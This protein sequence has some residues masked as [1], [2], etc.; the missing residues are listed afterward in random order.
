MS[1]YQGTF[2]VI[3]NTGAT[4]TNVLATHNT[5][6][7]GNETIVVASLANGASSQPQAFTT[8]TSN[9]DRW[10]VAFINSNNGLDTGY[11]TCG[12]ES[13]DNGG[14][15]TIELE[16]QEWDIQMPKSSSCTGNDY[17]QT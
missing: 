17:D 11:E 13:D 16:A 14:V 2:R 1:Q 8:S 9:K 5:T 12:F 6:D 3:N 4:I 7:Y 10:S 15:V